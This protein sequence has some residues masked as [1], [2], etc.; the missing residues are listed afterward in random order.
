MTGVQ[1]CALPILQRYLP[2]F[3]GGHSSRITVR[4]LLNHTSGIS[5]EAGD[6]PIL[7]QGPVGDNAI[8]TWAMALTPA[9]LN[10]P[11][12]ATFEY[13]NA[14]YIVLGAI[15]EAVSGER[16][17]QYLRVH[18]FEPL[19]M[20]HSYASFE[21]TQKNR[22]AQGHREWFGWFE[23][24]DV[25][26]PPSFVPV[27]FVVTSVGD[28]ARYLSMEA[29]GGELDGVHIVSEA[30]LREMHRGAAAMD[31]EGKSHY[32]MGWVADTFNGV[33]VVYHDG[34]TGRFTSVL[35]ISRA[36]HFGVVIL[37]NASGWLYGVHQT[38]AA[39]GATNILV[40]R[41]PKSY[42][43]PFLITKIGLGAVMVIALLQF[44]FF[45]RAFM[46]GAKRSLIRGYLVPTV[47]NAG[48]AFALA[49]VVPRVFFGIPLSELVSSVPDIG[50]ASLGS[51]ACALAWVLLTVSRQLWPQQASSPN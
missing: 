45:F 11:A 17:A 34:D 28:M 21:E 25:P 41:V 24:S 30:G 33:P 26:Y 40:G 20:H 1:T 10:R 49:Y 43:G 22:I 44:F 15:L 32:A 29:N 14:N 39:N 31:P 23:S 6:Q 7:S 27:G 5:H 12:G 47:L 3:M 2:N 46:N 38:D 18:V 4:M 48:C 42:A 16:Y 19:G 36:E 50:I 13:S 9:S 51:L 35:A 8:R 37:A